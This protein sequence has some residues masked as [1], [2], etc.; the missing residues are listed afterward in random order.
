MNPKLKAGG[1]WFM[2]TST[3]VGIPVT[4]ILSLLFI[5]KVIFTTTCTIAGWRCEYSIGA[6]DA[7]TDYMAELLAANPNRDLA[8]VPRQKGK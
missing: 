8:S 1:T 2:Q 6:T 5:Q 4:L 7:M 3:V